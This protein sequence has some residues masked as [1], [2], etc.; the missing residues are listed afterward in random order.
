MEIIKNYL[1]NVFQA[2]PQTQ[3]IL[4]LKAELLTNMNDKYDELKALG[5][6]ENEAIGIV[7]SEFGNIDELLKEMNINITPNTKPSLEKAMG[8]TVSLDGAK[9]FINLKRKSARFIGLG[10]ALILLGVAT[11]IGSLALIKGQIILG[12]VNS[13]SKDMFPIIMLFLFIVPAVGLFI[14]SG[15]QLEKYKESHCNIMNKSH[16]IYIG[17]WLQKW[18]IR[19]L[20]MV[21]N[22]NKNKKYIEIND[23][24]IIFYRWYGKRVLKREK[25]RAAYMDD[26]YVIRILYEK[27]IRRYNIS[28]IM[29]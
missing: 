23:E 15:L 24:N 16:I 26:N 1:D 7:I 18:N 19:G 4:N 21:I 3:E 22:N 2:L 25:I 28:N 6:T 5:K 11:L 17:K 12:Q 13:N 9:D 8:P 29:V 10:V 27:S 14:Y 20:G